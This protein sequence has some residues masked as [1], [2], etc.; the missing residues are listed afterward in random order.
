MSGADRV[1]AP[2]GVPLV[3]TEAAVCRPTWLMELE[4]VAIIRDEADYP[5]FL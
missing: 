1:L 5:P 4:G 3:L 2:D